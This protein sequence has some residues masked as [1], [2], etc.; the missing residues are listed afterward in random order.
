MRN[1]ILVLQ[2]YFADLAN[3]EPQSTTFY[4]QDLGS[5]IDNYYIHQYISDTNLLGI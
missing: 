1:E 3:Y 5:M 2:E 4:C